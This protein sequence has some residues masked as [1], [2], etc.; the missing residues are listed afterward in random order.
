MRKFVASLVAAVFLTAAVPRP[1][2]AGG[3][4]MAGIVLG[5][6]AGLVF[7]SMI[8]ERVLPPPPPNPNLVEL[9]KTEREAIRAQAAVAGAATLGENGRVAYNAR[10]RGVAICTGS[11]CGAGNDIL[12]PEVEYGEED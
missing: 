12:L 8:V 9:Q 10:G 2:Q 5:G 3:E 6:L 11:Q 4:A 1:A 7:G